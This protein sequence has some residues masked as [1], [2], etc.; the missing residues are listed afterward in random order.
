M[1]NIHKCLRIIS[2]KEPILHYLDSGARLR[3]SRGGYFITV[4]LLRRGARISTISKCSMVFL[5]T[6]IKT[7]A[8]PLLEIWGRLLNI[9]KKRVC[10]IK[11]NLLIFTF[12]YG[13]RLNITPTS[14]GQARPGLAVG[15]QTSVLKIEWTSV[16]RSQQDFGL[17][18]EHLARTALEEHL[19]PTIR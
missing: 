17:Q 4:R 3:A 14:Q 2:S 13:S 9:F 6:W 16:L 7:Y 19:E 1:R 8:R 15:T 12:C 11:R 18:H 5:N 10:V